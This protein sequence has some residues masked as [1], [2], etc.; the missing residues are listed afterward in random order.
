MSVALYAHKARLD[1]LVTVSL[2]ETSSQLSR[3]TEG[4]FQ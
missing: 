4:N 1:K 3:K 2:L